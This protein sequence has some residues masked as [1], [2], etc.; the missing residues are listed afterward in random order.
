MFML[1][2]FQL[3]ENMCISNMLVKHNES[4]KTM[5]PQLCFFLKK[6][7]IVNYVGACLFNCQILNNARQWCNAFNTVLLSLVYI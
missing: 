7:S 5:N 3:M 2:L 6:P 1:E 4:M